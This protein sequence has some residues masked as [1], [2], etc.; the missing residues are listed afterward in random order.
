MRTASGDYAPA[1][2]FA[3]DC[4]LSEAKPQAPDGHGLL[5]RSNR[6]ARAVRV[7]APLGEFPNQR[8]PHPDLCSAWGYRTDR[9]V[10]GYRTI[11]ILSHQSP[12]PPA[13]SPIDS[14][15]HL[16]PSNGAL[17]LINTSSVPTRRD[18]STSQQEAFRKRLR[19]KSSSFFDRCFSAETKPQKKCCAQGKSDEIFVAS[20]A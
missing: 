10:W 15:L 4:L 1:P 17:F 7:E 9:P 2:R 19:A 11:P 20:E 3:Q 6:S 8:P 13:S 14:D 16:S 5:T 18:D 12:H